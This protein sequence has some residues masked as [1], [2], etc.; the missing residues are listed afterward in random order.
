MYV[1]AKEIPM[2]DRGMVIH[3]GLTGMKVCQKSVLKLGIMLKC[4]VKE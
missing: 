4:R 1:R 2:A 3:L